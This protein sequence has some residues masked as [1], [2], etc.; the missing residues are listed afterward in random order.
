MSRRVSLLHRVIVALGIL[1]MF[2]SIMVAEAASVDSRVFGLLPLGISAEEV[3]QRLGPPDKMMLQPKRMQ[4][5]THRGQVALHEVERVVWFYSGE[6]R[7][8]DT[9][10]TLENGILVAK[11][12]RR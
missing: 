2:C 5:T 1:G 7:L 11:D 3:R 10:L 6:G 4:G 8:M 9:F 12:K